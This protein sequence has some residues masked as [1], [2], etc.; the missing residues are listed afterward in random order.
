MA[1]Q[2]TKNDKEVNIKWRVADITIPNEDIISVKEDTNIYAATEE[3]QENVVRIG[4]TFGKT[5]RILLET[6]DKHYIIYTHNDKKILD[7]LNK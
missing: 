3:N 4:S 5:N 1:M 6:K 2:V 7:E